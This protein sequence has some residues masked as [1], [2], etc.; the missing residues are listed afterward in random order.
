MGRVIRIKSG[1]S[2]IIFNQKNLHF[3]NRTRHILLGKGTTFFFFI[4]LVLSFLA[5]E[6]APKF[7]REIKE[8]R[9]KEGM[10][11]RYGHYFKYPTLPCTSHISKVRSERGDESKVRTLF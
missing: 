2:L 11:A 10:R 1:L 9:V 4:S 3:I 8:S 6:Q 5:T 7:V